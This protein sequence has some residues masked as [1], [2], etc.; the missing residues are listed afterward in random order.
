M[1]QGSPHSDISA[2]RDTACGRCGASLRQELASGLC[3]H[4]VTR[5]LCS[6]D[7]SELPPHPNG[8]PPGFECV[9]EL[10]RGGMGV[11]FLAY[12]RRLDRYVALKQ[13]GPALQRHPRAAERF[14]QEAR[15][16]A[17]L[18]HPGIVPV[19]EV[20]QH[21]DSAWYTM[22]YVEGG[23][24]AQALKVHGGRLN[25]PDAVAL[26][27]TVA[28]AID[29][30]HANGVVHRD[31]KPSNI[32]LDA[33]GAPKVADFGLAW[34]TGQELCELTA[35][36]ELLGTPA[37][38]A[39][40]CLA[41]RTRA[42]NTYAADIYAL[43]AVLF[44]LVAGRP[45]F[46]AEHPMQTLSAIAQQAAPLLN[47]IDGARNVPWELVDLCDCCLRK[48]PQ[49]R[50]RTA[51]QLGMALRKILSHHGSSSGLATRLKRVR[52]KTVVIV[53]IS[54]VL[55]SGSFVFFS[56]MSIR[57]GALTSTRTVMPVLVVLPIKSIGAASAVTLLAGGLQ[58]EI[59]AALNQVT[60]LQVISAGSARA[61]KPDVD[62]LARLHPVL[63]ADAALSCSV[64][65]WQELVRVSAQLISVRD[66]RVLWAAN[67][68]RR[69]T[70]LLN[71]QSD[72][73]T[74]VAVRLQ[75]RLSPNVRDAL[76]GTGSAVPKAQS[77][78][79]RAQMLVADASSSVK[80]LVEAET[81]LREAV[82]LDPRFALAFAR[83]SL[84][85]TLMYHWGNDR[86]EQRLTLGL[87]AAQ[88]ALRENPLL[89]EGKL[90]L[91]QYYLRGSRDFVTARR[92]IEDALKQSPSY[93][94]A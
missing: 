72:I 59:I 25:W 22:E 65:Q 2:G 94:D 88:S 84:V 1:T 61:S 66:G 40:E 49:D 89:A 47:S 75:A 51:A 77:A 37:Y 55:V 38:L 52:R 53:A 57:R 4:C 76:A 32:L 30:A 44:H 87:R 58:E 17:R 92:H 18:S 12:Q 48:R 33:N 74:D 60:N 41:G 27:A 67:Y 69:E 90:A 56:P 20:G 23:D 45:P 50:F 63:G 91:G 6:A 71:L 24:L 64:Q 68:D 10:G 26:I 85:H 3:W 82:N 46:H 15:A 42:D 5:R 13:L 29:M 36:G 21:G 9:T 86:S 19:L 70:N 93:A 62:D 16:A 14:I 8:F 78:L 11:V 7:G 34:V 54:A 73:A 39:P 43:G 83:L 79:L 31:L 35:T 28:E 81:L 80:N